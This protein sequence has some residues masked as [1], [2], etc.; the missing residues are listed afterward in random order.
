MVCSLSIF[1]H[2][3]HSVNATVSLPNGQ[4]APVTHID[5]VN[6]FANLT[7]HN[8]LY[9]PSFTF[10][11]ISTSKL[12]SSS[13]IGLVFLSNKCI[14]QDMLAWKTIGMADQK[15]GLYLLKS[16]SVSSTL[17]SNSSIPSCS[18]LLNVYYHYIL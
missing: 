9:V 11:L 4:V 2:I 16:T 8:V 10:N 7:L 6:V 13:N 1:S 18:S 5:T 14:L 3:S 12:T 17:S 15:D